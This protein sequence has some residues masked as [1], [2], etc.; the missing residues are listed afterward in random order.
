MGVAGRVWE[1][2]EYYKY[3]RN[4]N[5][6]IKSA[7][8]VDKEGKLMYLSKENNLNNYSSVLG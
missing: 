2:W 8:T 6:K 7:S 3:D 4:K 5:K 1:E